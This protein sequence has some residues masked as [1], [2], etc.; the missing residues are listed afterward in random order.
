[1]ELLA[2][3]RHLSLSEIEKIVTQIDTNS[4]RDEGKSF[5]YIS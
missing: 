1:M 3:N 2:V 4:I 5:I